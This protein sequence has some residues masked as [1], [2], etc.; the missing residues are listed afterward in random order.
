MKEN[1]DDD[2]GSL[3]RPVFVDDCATRVSLNVIVEIK[4]GGG[5]KILDRGG[6]GRGTDLK[7]ETKLP[8]IGM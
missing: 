5:L 8:Y 7:R 6:G 1:N 2:Q 4:G 3:A